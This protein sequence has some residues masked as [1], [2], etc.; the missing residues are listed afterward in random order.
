MHAG[1]DLFVVLGTLNEDAFVIG[2]HDFNE[3]GRDFRPLSEDFFGECVAQGP[4]SE[5]QVVARGP[6]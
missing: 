2:G 1:L 4:S 6:F 3:L 5:S